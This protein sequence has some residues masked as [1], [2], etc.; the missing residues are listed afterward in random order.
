MAYITREDMAVMLVRALGYESLAG[1]IASLGVPSPDVTSHPGHIALSAAIGMTTG[2]EVDG[3]LLF[4][5]DAFATRG[6]AAAM[7]FPC[8]RA[9]L[10]NHRLAQWLLRLLLVFP[11]LLYRRDGRGVGGLGPNEL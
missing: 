4:Q 5:P 9:L 2:V 11:N 8:P 3:Q 6:Q 1:D 10:L 7:L